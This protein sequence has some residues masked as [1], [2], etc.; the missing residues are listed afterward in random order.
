[1]LLVSS[2]AVASANAAPQ[3]KDVVVDKEGKVVRS[4]VSKECV[5]TKWDSET[6]KCGTEVAKAP[7]FVEHKR[8]YMIFF[9]W[10]KTN[11]TSEASTVLTDLVTQ[12]KD[13]GDV[14]YD[15]TAHADRSGSDDYNLGLSE[16]RASATKDALQNLGVNPDHVTLSWKGEREPLVQTDDNIREPQNRRAEINVKVGA[17]Q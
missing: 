9:D 8:S 3:N 11:I 17:E 2:F 5:R 15:I 16:R 7:E 10:D 4:I 14:H 13:E 12:T 6:D 1:M